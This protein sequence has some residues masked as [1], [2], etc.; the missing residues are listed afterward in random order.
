MSQC[1]DVQWRCLRLNLTGAARRGHQS[2]WCNIGRPSLCCMFLGRV[3][4]A[5]WL[6]G[7]HRGLPHASPRGIHTRPWRC[8][9]DV[10]R[11]RLAAPPMKNSDERRRNGISICIWFG[12]VGSVLLGWR[13][14]SL[15]AADRFKF[16]SGASASAGRLRP[17]DGPAEP[18]HVMAPLNVPWTVPDSL[19]AEWPE[20]AG[21]HEVS[22]G[23]CG[24]TIVIADG[25]I[26]RFTRS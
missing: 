17:L 13:H 23:R 26:L 6:G 12:A 25:A 9:I 1:F 11:A 24:V 20:L 16:A 7:I 4:A 5:T 14:A 2:T 3:P 15:T 10:S 19:F 21:R 18:S 22:S 8:R